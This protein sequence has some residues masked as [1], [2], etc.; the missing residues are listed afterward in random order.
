M[1]IGFVLNDDEDT[2]TPLK[3]AES[4]IDADVFS[5]KELKELIAYLSIYTRYNQ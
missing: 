2:V 3:A 1:N 5:I 4:I